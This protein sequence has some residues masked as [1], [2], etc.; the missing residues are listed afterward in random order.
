MRRSL[1]LNILHNLQQV[2]K[3][4]MQTH[5][6]T[7][8]PRLS[9]VQKMTAALWILQHSAPADPVD[10]YIRINE[11]TAI[12]ALSFFTKTIIA[13]YE[14]VYLRSPNEADVTRLLQ[15]GEQHGFPEMLGSLDCM[16]WRCDTC[17]TAQ[18]SAYTGH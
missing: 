11:T 2:N 5:D 18:A 17:L 10:E 13:I 9:S 14:G 12:A 16:H 8:A 15:K 1:F 6:A 3:H 7:G 4:F